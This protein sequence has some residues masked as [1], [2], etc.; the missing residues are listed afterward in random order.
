LQFADEHGIDYRLSGKRS[1]FVRE[2]SVEL[3]ARK[4]L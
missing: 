1:R 4:L 3:N 2:R